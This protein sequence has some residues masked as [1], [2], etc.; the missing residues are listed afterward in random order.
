[1]FVTHAP[2]ID[3]AKL[4]HQSGIENVYYK[5]EYRSTEG[6]DFLEKCSIMVEKLS[7]EGEENV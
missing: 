4:I 1:L 3:C 7:N 2:C 6:V 5:N